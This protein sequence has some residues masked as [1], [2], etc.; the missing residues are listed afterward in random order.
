MKEI[1][2]L[3]DIEQAKSRSVDRLRKIFVEPFSENPTLY[4]RTTKVCKHIDAHKKKHNNLCGKKC[5]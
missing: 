1:N 4:M 5:S 3:Y 2:P